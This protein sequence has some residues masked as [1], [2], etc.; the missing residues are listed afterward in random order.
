M[1]VKINNSTR[2]KKYPFNYNSMKVRLY[3]DR[4]MLNL[5]I[6]YSL[7]ESKYITRSNLNNLQ[8]LFNILDDDVYT[9]NIETFARVQMIRSIL[10]AKL[11]RG[12]ENYDVIINYLNEEN[13][14]EY[15]KI[16]S[17]IPEYK[18]MLNFN[19]IKFINKAIMDRL[20]YAFIIYYKDLIQNSFLRIDTNDYRALEDIVNEV[21]DEISWLMN[22]IRKTE[23]VASMEVFS[24]NDEAF[25]PLVEKTIG[26]LLDP[27]NTLRTGIKALNDMLC[28]GFMPGRFYLWLGVSGGGKSN[29]L[30]QCSRWI[31]LFNK[32]VPKRK[33]EN[34]IPTVLHITMENTVAES[35]V[36]MFNMCVTDEDITNFTP[37]E[38]VKLL[39]SRG[40]MTLDKGEI[41]IMLRFYA[42]HEISTD[43]LYGIIE[44]IEDDNREVIA[45]VVDYIKRIRP[46]N[47]SPDE[48]IQLKNASNELKDLANRLQIPV[49]TAQQINRAGN[50]A[51]DE[52]IKSGKADIVNSVGSTDVGISWELIENSDW[53]GIIMSTT[54]F[55]NGK[56][57]LSIKN[58]KCR[59]KRKTNITSI[60]H[61]YVEGSTIRLIDDVNMEESLSV[62]SLS[63]IVQTKKKKERNELEDELY[64]NEDDEFDFNSFI[65]SRK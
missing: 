45:L 19:E 11:H 38:A 49:I 53:V 39:R 1:A 20:K 40:K 13:N 33:D 42:N 46:A 23:S 32:I 8:K 51:V 6:G 56:N 3:F 16:I 36:R 14:N 22:D 50:N 21:K 26:D 44:D 30:L 31:K 41:D 27:A 28:G 18:D 25:E 4:T 24:L 7:T 17:E 47:Y 10:E 35:V 64:G 15:G 2:K 12:L 58:P 9:Q 55:S 34:C 63:N 62:E 37:K 59:M 54:L 48:R 52:A 43:D 60:S 61:P 5:F 29:I 57:Y 65:K